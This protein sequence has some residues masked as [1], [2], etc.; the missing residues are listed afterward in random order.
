[1][2]L[3]YLRTIAN[4][5]TTHIKTRAII[6]LFPELASQVWLDT[7]FLMESEAQNACSDQASITSEDHVMDTA[8]L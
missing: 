6:A 1:M 3:P 2:G 5:L 8:P 4:W 7:T